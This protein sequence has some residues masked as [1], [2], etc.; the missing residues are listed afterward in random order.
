IKSVTITRDGRSHQYLNNPESPRDVAQFGALIHSWIPG[1]AMRSL[2]VL[3]PLGPTFD[4]AQFNATH[5]TWSDPR[6]P[7]VPTRIE[8]QSARNESMAMLVQAYE[9]LIPLG[10]GRYFVG[11]ARPG[12]EGGPTRLQLY[13][14][15]PQQV[16]LCI[17]KST[18][19]GASSSGVDQNA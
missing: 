14:E 15:Y 11:N 7:T 18:L 2:T 5:T 13:R 19:S 6:H 3:E 1:L 17:P 12:A 9:H 10:N 8:S 16:V 4:S